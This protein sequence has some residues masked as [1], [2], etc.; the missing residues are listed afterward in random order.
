MT[1]V[2][3]EPAAGPGTHLLIIGGGAYAYGRGGP[4]GLAG[5]QRCGSAHFTAQIGAGNRRLFYHVLS[6]CRAPAG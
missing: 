3:E 2:F 1:L 6:Q 5:W 4:F